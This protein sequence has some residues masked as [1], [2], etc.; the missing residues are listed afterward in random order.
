ME[1]IACDNVRIIYRYLGDEE[2]RE[3]KN[4]D[5][6]N[7]SSGPDDS[8][9]ITEVSVD[10]PLF[11]A[12]KTAAL[13]ANPFLRNERMPVRIDAI[14]DGGVAGSVMAFPAQIVADGVTYGCNGGSSLYV[15]P[16]CRGY[17]IGSKLAVERLNAARAKISLAAGLSHMSKPLYEKLG[18]HVFLTERLVL[19]KNARP[20]VSKY[21]RQRYASAIAGGI[22]N[23]MLRLQQ[24]CIKAYIRCFL[25]DYHIKKA[26]RAVPEV[27]RIIAGTSARFRE[28]HPTAW[29]DWHLHHTFAPAP[30]NGQS[31]YLVERE[32]ET[33]GFFLTKTRIRNEFTQKKFK[34]VVLGSVIEWGSTGALSERDVCLLAL[35]SF[36]KADMVELC[37]DHNPTI[38]LLKRFLLRRAGYGNFAIYAG[39]G[40]PLH[41]HPGFERQH[42]WRIR[43]ACS[44]NGLS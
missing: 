5:F 8:E 11:D 15:D 37:T 1:K 43:P 31:L 42:N 26:N 27:E 40:S 25:G 36:Q 12:A 35:D 21:I 17:G 34:G 29:F 28:D 10:A 18:C 7:S 14:M 38:R 2:R 19:L 3:R 4:A 30:Q 41:A 9:S 20:F 33:L 22:V 32:G 39:E 6:D 23:G 24:L 44:D 13:R 16:N